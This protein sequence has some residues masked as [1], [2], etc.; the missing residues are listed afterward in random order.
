MDIDYQGGYAI[1]PDA[2][3]TDPDKKQDYIDNGTERIDPTRYYSPEFMKAEWDHMWTKSWTLAGPVSDVKD[4]GDYF[5]YNIGTESIIVSRDMTG[6]IHAMYNVCPHR[7]NQLTQ[8]EFGSQNSFTCAFHSWKFDLAG[9][10]L[11]V[12][13]KKTFRPEVL[14][15]G[16]DVTPVK[17]GVAAGLIFVALNEDAMPLEEFLG[18][19]LPQLESYEIEK[20]H[21]VSHIRSE[22]AAN[23]KTGVDAFYELYHLHA[24]HPE[25]QGV[26]EDYRAQYDLYPNGMSRMIVPFAVASSRGDQE[27][28]NEGLQSMLA[29]AGIDPS[30]YPASG[31]K[32]RGAIQAAKRKMSEKLGLGY[33]RFTDSQL[34]DSFA[35]GI[36]PNVQLGC[37]P[38]G[39][40]MMRFLP[41]PTDPARFYYDNIIM[42]RNVESAE[43]KTPD[44]MGLPE[45]ADLS[46]EMRPDIIH[47]PVDE[48]P[49]LGLVLNQDSELLPYVQAGLT[50]RGFKGPL[51]GEQECRL[52]HFHKELDRYLEGSK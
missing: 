47:I 20:M 1:N 26:M 36:F 35:T 44:W 52:R 22:W 30:Q 48:K 37:H 9:K 5:L 12:T 21:A 2:T 8:Q 34:T 10:C 16:H 45:D 15:K 51:W 28:V 25:T 3:E 33:D 31:K 49:D 27:T 13:D 4:P 50:S 7:G 6:E 17:V 46:G 14:C 23:W 18:P 19:L 29:D 11:S 24:V 32:V 41:H 43:Y 42:Y 39:V 40:F 38:E